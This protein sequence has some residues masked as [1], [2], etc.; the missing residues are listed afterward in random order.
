MS[1]VAAG[2]PS[3][4]RQDPCRRVATL[5]VGIL[6]SLHGGVALAQS[7][8]PAEVISIERA[9]LIPMT[10]RTPFVLEAHT[11]VVRNER[12]ADICPSS[13]GCTPSGARVIDGAGKFVI[14][15]L[16]DMH[17]H[18]GGFAWDG[19]DASRIRMR[20]QNL[21]QY[22]MFGIA[23]TRDPSGGP[24]VL[25][26][27]DAIERGDLFGPRVFVSSPLMDG[28]PPLFP[29]PRTFTA[30]EEA[31]EFIRRSAAEGYD[32]AKVYTALSPEVFDAVMTAAAETGL[33]VAAHVPVLVPLEH[34]LEKGLRSIEH[35][36]GYDVACA[37]PRVSM[38]PVAQDIY[39][40]WAWCSPEKVAELAA[41]TARYDVW[42][43]PTLALWDNT[44]T[45]F[46]RPERDGGEVGKYEHPTTPG[47]I[48]WL[49]TL[50]G[51][52]ERAGITGT[53]SARLGLVKALHDAGAPLLVGTDVSAIGYTVHREMGL[54]VEAGLTPYQVL[55]A[56]TSEAAR[57]MGREGEF[58]V[59]AV[60]ARGDVL[61]LDAS[62][63]EDIGAT[64]RIHGLMFRD[65]WWSK[66]A[67]DA[68]L[69][70]LQREYAEDE[71]RLR[72]L[73]IGGR[74]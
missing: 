22:V 55:E 45:E 59:L 41:L 5:L 4:P 20:D 53:R 48:E 71:A 29:L 74:Q 50:Y 13:A 52:R 61:L 54:F 40:G 17:N 39:Q 72:E 64:R 63:L 51:P 12:I 7:S 73:G 44:V 23:T 24:Q 65:K 38:R 1:R 30:P 42:N 6:A 3:G 18:F 43:V 25:E 2:C 35:L 32:L 37:A 46:D 67:I 57:Y 62:P 33:T 66:Q 21:R 68:E 56:A 36:T 19:T 70:A 11:L 60:G 9:T 10:S 34:A 28:D 15:A 8:S 58:G 26:M 49:Y 47:G 16:A 69:E 27:R 31:A 14:P